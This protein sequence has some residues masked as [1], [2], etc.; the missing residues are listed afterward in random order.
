MEEG[1]QQECG[2]DGRGGKQ[3]ECDGG[4]CGGGRGKA[5]EMWW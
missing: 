2:G 1:K 3:W 5:I 4:G